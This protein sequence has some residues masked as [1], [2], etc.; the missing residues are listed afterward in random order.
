E[1]ELVKVEFEHLDLYI[2]KTPKEASLDKKKKPAKPASREVPEIDLHIH[3]LMDFYNHLS[4]SEIVLKQL[5]ACKAFLHSSMAKGFR[6]MIIVHGVGE[7]VLR[8]EVHWLLDGFP[9]LQYHDAS[10]RKYGYG[11]TEVIVI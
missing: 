7:G 4:N 2:P 10:Y 3:E 8:S 6:K 5:S 1:N 11:A 9:N